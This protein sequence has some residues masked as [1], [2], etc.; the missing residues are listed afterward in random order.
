MTF[1]L[2]AHPIVWPVGFA[3]Q[4]RWS[5]PKRALRAFGRNRLHRRRSKVFVKRLLSVC[6]A[7]LMLGLLPA[8]ADTVCPRPRCLTI[9]VPVSPGLTVP[10]NHVRVILP[11][12]YDPA[13]SYPVLYLIHGAG[14][15]YATWTQNTDVLSF[16]AAYRVIIA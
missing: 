15:T 9:E 5:P 16:S 6:A 4:G 7:V 11:M 2:I 12:D 13:Q 10:D 1:L 14:D 3:D 8:R